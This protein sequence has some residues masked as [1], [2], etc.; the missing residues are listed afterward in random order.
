MRQATERLKFTLRPPPSVFFSL[1]K[2]FDFLDEM[3][4]AS[5]ATHLLGGEAI[6][7]GWHYLKGVAGLAVLLCAAL[8]STYASIQC[9]SFRGP[10]FVLP[11]S[12]SSL[13]PSPFE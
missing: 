12:R 5:A 6:E 8:A 10:L 11:P 2:A 9:V 1:P 7:D 13:P 4:G 3:R